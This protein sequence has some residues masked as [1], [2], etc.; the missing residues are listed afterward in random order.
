MSERDD[1]GPAFPIPVISQNQTTG[2]T[3]IWQTEGGMS[4][5][6]YFIA[7]APAEPWPEFDPVMPTGRP[8]SMWA[9][10]D[11]PDDGPRFHCARAAELHY[12]CDGEFVINEAK[13]EQSEWDGERDLQRR[14]QWPAFWADAMLLAR[15]LPNRDA[16]KVK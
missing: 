7:H 3:S 8:L 9:H 2:E 15:L 5:R 12:Q 10:E 13:L 11:A 14:I 16:L 6:D 1:G 4:L